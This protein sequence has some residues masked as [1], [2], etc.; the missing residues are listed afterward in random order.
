[1]DELPQGASKRLPPHSEI[2]E[3]GK[4]TGTCPGTIVA[5]VY[6]DVGL[7]YGSCPECHGGF[8]YLANKNAWVEENAFEENLKK[9][10]PELIG[11]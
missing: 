5:G 9:N 8:V 1:M 7:F 4:P 3:D 10:P 2:G 6:S 11:Y